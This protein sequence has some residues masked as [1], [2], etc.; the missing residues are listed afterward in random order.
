MAPAGPC[1]KGWTLLEVLVVAAVLALLLAILVPSLVRARE[2]SRGAQCLS[3]LRQMAI[4]A[5]GYAAAQ[6][7]FPP[8][9]YGSPDGMVSC[10][11]DLLVR[12]RWEGGRRVS[13]VQPGLLWQGKTIAQIN[14]CPKYEGGDNWVD[15]PFTG[16]NYNSSYVGYCL[17]R[18]ELT[19]WPPRPTGRLIADADPARPD[20]VRRPAGCALFGDG[21]YV[22]GANKFMRSPFRGRDASFSGRSAGTQGY[23][24]LLRTN[25]TFADG[26]GEPWSR[27]FDET[28]EFDKG[29]IKPHGSVPT[30]F[31]SPDNSLY[32]LE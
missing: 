14:Q 20:D 8:Y 15:Y 31:L 30:G 7:R 22:A 6:R 3:N 26:H 2:L 9:L 12:H 10:A 23:R 16:Y 29:N 11:W 5:H 13:T 27:R 17:Y 32:D 21:E 24:H 4:A 1:R 19:G 28:Y 18:A 25:V